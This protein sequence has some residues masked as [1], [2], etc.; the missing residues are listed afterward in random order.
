MDPINAL[1]R[2]VEASGKSTRQIARELGRS[3]S[4]VR[5]TISQ[6]SRPRIDTFLAIAQACGY[7]MVMASPADEFTLSQGSE[8]EQGDTGFSTVSYSSVAL[9]D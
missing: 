4:F 2:M 1:R 8:L 3:D 6:K 9:E 7:E 5:A